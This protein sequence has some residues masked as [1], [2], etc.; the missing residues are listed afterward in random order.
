VTEPMPDNLLERR[1]RVRSLLGRVFRQGGGLLHHP[2]Y[3]TWRRALT[4]LHPEGEEAPPGQAV[5]FAIDLHTAHGVP[6]EQLLAVTSLTVGT[7]HDRDPKPD[8]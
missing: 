6:I 5:G 2:A 8:T 7:R 3:D 4:E 1:E